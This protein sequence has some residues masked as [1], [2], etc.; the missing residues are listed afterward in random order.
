MQKCLNFKKYIGLKSL[1]A[2]ETKALAK[3]SEK[4]RNGIDAIDG[5]ERELHS[6]GFE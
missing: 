6:P 5:N 4:G 3:F 1:R 2:F